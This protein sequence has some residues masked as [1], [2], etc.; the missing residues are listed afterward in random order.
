MS[1]VVRCCM[2]ISYCL[3]SVCDFKILGSNHLCRWKF[4]ERV[5]FNL[6]CVKKHLHCVLTF[7]FM[8][9][10]F[11]FFFSMVLMLQH[12]VLQVLLDMSLKDNKNYNFENYFHCFSFF[13]RFYV[14]QTPHPCPPVLSWYPLLNLK[15]SA[16]V[17][18]PSPLVYLKNNSANP[19]QP[20]TAKKNVGPHWE[21]FQFKRL[22]WELFCCKSLMS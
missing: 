10:F 21:I 13:W 19:K 16:S 8:L 5:I 12:I 7:I 9:F 14:L 17:T 3:Y 6:F 15:H 4:V 11:H 18:Q 2:Y 1:W 22:L 20:P